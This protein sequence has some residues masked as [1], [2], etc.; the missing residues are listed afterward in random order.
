[1][2]FNYYYFPVK[3]PL[4]PAFNSRSLELQLCEISKET[5]TPPLLPRRKVQSFSL[6]KRKI[7]RIEIAIA[8]FLALTRCSFPLPPPSQCLVIVENYRGGGQTDGRQQ[9]ISHTVSKAAKIGHCPQSVSAS[10]YQPSNTTS[11]TFPNER[12]FE[13]FV[14]AEI[15]VK[16]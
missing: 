10:F 6:E 16:T 4:P 8:S 13:L 12:N 15:F 3:T 2:S 7:E 14:F 9:E 1:M 11:L 5:P